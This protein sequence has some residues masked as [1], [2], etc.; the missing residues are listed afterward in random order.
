MNSEDFYI[1]SCF[2]VS[3]CQLLKIVTA[4]QNLQFEL[5]GQIHKKYLKLESNAV[6]NLVKIND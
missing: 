1:F 2:R 3:I 4:L 6:A 5:I